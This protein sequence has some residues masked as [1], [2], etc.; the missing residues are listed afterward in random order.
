MADQPKPGA[1]HRAAQRLLRPAR[2]RLRCRRPCRLTPSNRRVRTRTHGG[3]GGAEPRGSPLSRLRYGPSDDSALAPASELVVAGRIRPAT[4]NTGRMTERFST[5]GR[6]SGARHRPGPRPAADDGP[7]TRERHRL[8]CG[9]PSRA[10]GRRPGEVTLGFTDRCPAPDGDSDRR[11][12]TRSGSGRSPGSARPAYGQ[13]GTGRNSRRQAKGIDP[14]ASCETRD[15]PSFPWRRRRGE[16]RSAGGMQRSQDGSDRAREAGDTGVH[17]ACL[18]VINRV[19]GCL[20]G[21]R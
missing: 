2:P 12:T 20:T 14:G 16:G 9:S 4:E 15:R 17:G 11:R 5:C 10:P 7:L 13:I 18:P 3:V 21:Y 19:I 1:L 8:A 6:S